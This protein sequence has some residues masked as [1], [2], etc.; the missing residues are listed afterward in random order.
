MGSKYRRLRKA[1]RGRPKGAVFKMRNVQARRSKIGNMRTPLKERL[2]R[3][4]IQSFNREKP[5]KILFVCT[6]NME[7]SPAAERLIKNIPRLKVKSAGLSTMEGVIDNV[8]QLTYHLVAW[9]DIIFVMDQH[10]KRVITKHIPSAGRKIVVLNV[11]D[12]Y[13]STYDP[14]LRSL[15]RQRLSRYFPELQKRFFS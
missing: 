13:Q 11:P 2:L 15:L 5:G 12:V 1:R 6:A 7:R 8:T 10:H 4:H 14:K 3:E 9:S